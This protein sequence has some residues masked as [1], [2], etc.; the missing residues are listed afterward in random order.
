[1]NLKDKGRST[2]RTLAISVLVRERMDEE[3][4]MEG[5]GG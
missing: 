5:A 1:M 4:D 2:K 3:E